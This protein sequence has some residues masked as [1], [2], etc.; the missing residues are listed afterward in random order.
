MATHI[1]WLVS[2]CSTSGCSYGENC[3]FQHYV[4][5][6]VGALGKIGFGTSGVTSGPKNLVLSTIKKEGGLNN[7]L[8]TRI[9]NLYGTA[10]GC[11]FGDKCHFAHGEQEL[12]K[13]NALPLAKEQ[14]ALSSFDG[15]LSADSLLGASGVEKRSSGIAQGRYEP[16]PPGIV[17]AAA[18]FGASS[19]AK[20]SIEASVAGIV[21]GKAGVNAKQI[22]RLTG[23]RLV[24]RDHE[25]DPA[26]KNIELEG[27][28]DQIKLASQMVQE[29]LIHKDTIS[30]KPTGFVAAN[31][32]KTKMCENYSKGVCTFRE[33]CHFA[34]SAS[35]LRDH[36]FRP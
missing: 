32:F 25:T 14:A 9:C 8:K 12:R 26:F 6:G 11:G 22:S 36:S 20:I 27:S 21:I 29:V 18:S 24:V 30:T 16:T 31:N 33:R 4:P 17:P 28:F 34:H 15:S 2:P 5:G 7:L 1:S 10:D 19:T 35:E 23:A 3:H 13:S